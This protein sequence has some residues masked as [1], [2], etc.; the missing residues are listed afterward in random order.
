[1]PRFTRIFIEPLYRVLF[2]RPLVDGVSTDSG[3]KA[4]VVVADGVGGFDVCGT[5][6]R[7]VLGRVGMPYAIHVFPWGHG[8]GRWLSDLTDVPHRDRKAKLLAQIVLR[9]KERNPTD[10]VYLIAKSGGC[11]VVVEALEKLGENAVERVVLLAP[12][13]SPAYDLTAALRAVAKEMVV[14][15]S[16]LDVF[17]LGVGTRIFGTADRVRTAGAGLVGFRIPASGSG[18]ERA[19]QYAKLNQV[20]WRVR[21]ASSGYLGGHFGPDSPV[22]LR[23]YVVPLLRSGPGAESRI[24]GQDQ[25][26][27]RPDRY[28]YGPGRRLPRELP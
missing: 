7:Y 19:R 2:G 6:L 12:A 25:A 4:F 21:M 14:F 13:L 24:D 22:F 8:L 16:P 11:A 27:A 1:M 23:K 3:V 15:W 17:I 10:P 20:R 28:P 5:G 18:Q 26:A 9:F